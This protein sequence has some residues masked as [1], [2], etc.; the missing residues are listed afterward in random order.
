M[1]LRLAF[2]SRWPISSTMKFERSFHPNLRL[3]LRDKRELLRQALVVW[4]YEADRRFL[5]GETYGVRVTRKEVEE[6]DEASPDLRAFIGRKAIYV[7]STAILPRFR[8]Q[9]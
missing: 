4:L 8:G 7:Y 5:I 2:T 9:G 3:S 6:S 1:K